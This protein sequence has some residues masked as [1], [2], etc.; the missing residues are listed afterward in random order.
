MK[1]LIVIMIRY[2]DSHNCDYLYPLKGSITP[3]FSLFVKDR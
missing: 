1:D 3:I 2:H